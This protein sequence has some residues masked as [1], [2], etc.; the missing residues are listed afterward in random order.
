MTEI[1]TIKSSNPR[2]IAHYSE[3]TV[4]D[5]LV[6]AAGQLASDFKTG[7]PPEAK[8]HPNFPYYGSDIKLQTRFIMEN[9]ARTLAA[10][11]SSLDEVLKAQVFM[12]DL[13]DFAAYDE[14]WRE[15]FKVPPPRTTVGM[16]EL[17][18]KDT[19]IEIDLIGYVPGTLPKHAVITSDNPKPLA[20]YSEATRIG[21]LVFAAGQLASDFKNGVAPESQ[22]PR[23]LS[24]LWFRHPAADR[25]HS[26]APEEHVRERRQFAR[27]RCKG[28]SVTYGPQRFRRLRSGLE[29]I[30]QGAA[31][32]HNGWHHWPFNQR[33]A[34]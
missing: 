12:T 26:A 23:E 14:V 24:I 16:H 22:T 28:A 6:F 13:H 31:A 32:A 21:D 27:S 17:L 8:K 1:K 11:G 30:L 15:Y 34:D 20:N 25:I 19:L 9:L 3:A 2:P 18:I 7:V 4:A 5:G 29:E 10:A 33:H